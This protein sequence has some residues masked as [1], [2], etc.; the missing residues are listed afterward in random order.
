[1]DSSQTSKSVIVIQILV[2]LVGNKLVYSCLQKCS[3]SCNITLNVLV[4]KTKFRPG[5]C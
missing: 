5:E 1:M 4:V 2:Q 3:C